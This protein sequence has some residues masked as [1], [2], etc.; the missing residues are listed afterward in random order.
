MTKPGT[1]TEAIR[2]R[3]EPGTPEAGPIEGTRRREQPEP[4][5]PWED[6]PDEER[7][8]DDELEPL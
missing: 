4:R 8:G 1:G 6:D 2:M 3:A 7:P 5:P